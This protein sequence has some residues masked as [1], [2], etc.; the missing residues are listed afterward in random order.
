M[1]LAVLL[2]AAAGC[3]T[4][5]KAPGEDGAGIPE[6]PPS[7]SVEAVELIDTTWRLVTVT[8]GHMTTTLPKRSNATLRFSKKSVQTNSGC[9][10]G[11][12]SVEIGDG[13]LEFGSLVTTLIAC[14][15]KWK[16]QVEQSY[17]QVLQGATT[18]VIE[19][20]RLTI[21]KDD[22]ALEFVAR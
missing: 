5:D 18:Y 17:G 1:L 6:A 21:T 11:G 13:S 9:N 15:E 2:L 10:S 12:G 7:N 8:E 14:P 4:E 20:D 16:Q 3:S 22:H 19:G